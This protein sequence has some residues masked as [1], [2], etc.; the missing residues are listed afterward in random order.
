MSSLKTNWLKWNPDYDNAA[1]SFDKAGMSID[2][3][4]KSLVVL[5]EDCCLVEAIVS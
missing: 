1:H 5:Q 3:N 2:K 4:G